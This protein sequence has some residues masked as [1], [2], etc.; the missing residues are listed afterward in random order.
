MSTLIVYS[1]ISGNTKAVCE[2]ICGALN[3]EK[4]IVNVKNLENINVEQYKNIIIG[5]WCDKGTMDKNSLEFL[6]TL[7]DKDLY[8]LGTLGARP[9]SE[10]WKDVFEKA[11]SLLSEKNNYKGGLLVWGRLSQ[12]IKDRI[13]Q[14]PK[15]HPHGVNPERL[16]RWK[17]A[18]SHPDEN[19]FKEAEE[20]FSNL[21]NI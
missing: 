20:Y 10:H 8:F 21:L 4:K 16:A 19:D 14:L 18:D 5:F 17:E 7:K 11:K 2:R 9:N 13:S 1:T 15:D 6:K 3:C 12:E